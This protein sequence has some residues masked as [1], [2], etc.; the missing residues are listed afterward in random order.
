VSFGRSLKATID[1]VVGTLGGAIYAGAVAALVP[2][3][4]E[5]ALATH[6]RCHRRRLR[7]GDR[8]SRLSL[9]RRSGSFA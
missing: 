2:H 9:G 8:G 4:N 7:R 5:I 3:A 1:Y 6:G